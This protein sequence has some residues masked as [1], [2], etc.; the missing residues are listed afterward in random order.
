MYQTCKILKNQ[1]PLHDHI[2]WLWEGHLLPSS[3]RKS[4]VCYAKLLK[5][6]YNSVGVASLIKLNWGLFGRVLV[7]LV[8]VQASRLTWPHF[9]WKLKAYILKIYPLQ[10]PKP[11]EQT[12]KKPWMYFRSIQCETHYVWNYQLN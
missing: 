5:I 11:A 6:F 2:M 10:S 3:A 9:W 8:H 7:E 12:T 1:I 4:R